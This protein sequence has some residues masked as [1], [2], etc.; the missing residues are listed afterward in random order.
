MIWHDCCSHFERNVPKPEVPINNLLGERWINDSE[1]VN[2]ET[3][4]SPIQLAQV[5]PNPIKWQPW[6]L[7]RGMGCREMRGEWESERKEEYPEI[8]LFCVVSQRPCTTSR[9]LWPDPLTSAIGKA[10]QS[11]GLR[12]SD[13]RLILHPQNT[14]QKGTITSPLLIF[15]I[16]FILIVRGLFKFTSLSIQKLCI[17]IRLLNY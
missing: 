1:S 7:S 8:V 6:N 9:P 4:I 15:G 17:N 13:S 5:F 3:Q 11:S 16:K 2:V 14:P 10:K 12:P